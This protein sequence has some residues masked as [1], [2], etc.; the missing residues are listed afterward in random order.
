MRK[1]TAKKSLMQASASIE[2]ENLGL[3][4]MNWEW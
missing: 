2:N 4:H 1:R 3:L